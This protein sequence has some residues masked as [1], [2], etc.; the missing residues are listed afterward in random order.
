M[1]GPLAHL[2]VL[3]MPRPAGLTAEPAVVADTGAP[4]HLI[5]FELPLHP[6]SNCQ[7]TATDTGAAHYAVAAVATSL[8]FMMKSLVIVAA[9]GL[10]GVRPR[11]RGRRA[12]WLRPLNILDARFAKV[13]VQFDF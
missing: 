3:A 12:T 7:V 13:G 1:T 10:R 8:V 2:D 9:A 11:R 6:A 5:V 4:G